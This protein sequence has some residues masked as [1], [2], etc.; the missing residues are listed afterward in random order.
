ML[1][2]LPTPFLFALVVSA[3]LVPPAQ[4][5][6]P[7]V[8][9]APALSNPFLPGLEQHLGLTYAN[10]GDRALQLDLYRPSVRDRPLPAI[11]G[12]HGGGWQKGTRENFRRVAQALAA[13]GYVTV[14]ISYRLSGESGFP[15]QIEDCKAAVRWLRANSALYGLDPRRIGAI[16]HSAGGHLAALLATSGGVSALEGTGGHSG[17]SSALLAAVAMGAQTDFESARNGAISADPEMGAIW[18]QFLGGTQAGLP[19][20]YRL[21]SPLH[22]LDRSDPPVYFI[23]GEE[24]DLSTRADLFRAR[25]EELG[26][27]TGLT[28]LPGAPHSFLGNTDWFTQAIQVAADFFSVHLQAPPPAAP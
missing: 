11:V 5:P 2:L 28:V 16:G 26:L 22:H 7:A 19:A 24:D 3:S 12:I 27:P 25:M 17:Q 9:A 15:A 6:A 18:R 23:T 1:P 20:V 14:A 8:T 13:R 21:A 10:Y 4:A